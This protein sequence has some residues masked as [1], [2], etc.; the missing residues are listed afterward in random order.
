LAIVIAI[1]NQKGGVGKTATAANLAACLAECGKRTL[2]VDLDY[3]ANASSYLG[4]KF[5]AKKL[6]KSTAS[7]I[8]GESRLS[9]TVIKTSHPNLDLLAGDMVLSK[10]A[11]EKILEPGSALLLKKAFE[12]KEAKAYDIILI[13]T[14]PSLDL[15]FQMA[16]SAADFYLV[17]MFAEADPFDGL[18]YMFSEITNIKST[19]NRNLGFLGLVITKFDKQNSTHVKFLEL[20]EHFCKSNKIA[21][22]GHIPDSK[23]LAGSSSHQKPLI[24]YKPDLPVSEAY[25]AL[26]KKL[27]RDLT[28]AKGSSTNA[29]PKVKGTPS[30]IMNLFGESRNMEIF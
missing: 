3:Q 27:V 22:R 12:Q 10:L 8:T 6:S 23:A 15:L 7:V 2:L 20:L 4:L 11:R 21:I 30:E 16:L 25:L 26:A 24:W 17:P 1:A 14:H 29:T 9:Q 28:S 13:D 5:E 18:Q 19:L